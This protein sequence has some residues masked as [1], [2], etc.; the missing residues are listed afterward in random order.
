MVLK[1]RGEGQEDHN[2]SPYLELICEV[3]SRLQWNGP[4]ILE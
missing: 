4:I 2:T 3:T 1:Q